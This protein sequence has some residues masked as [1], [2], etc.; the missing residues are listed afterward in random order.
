M[1]DDYLPSAFVPHGE[2]QELSMQ[3]PE[4]RQN[5]PEQIQ[6]A[7]LTLV[8]GSLRQRLGQLLNRNPRSAKYTLLLPDGR[9]LIL[10]CA[11]LSQLVCGCVCTEQNKEV[12]C[13]L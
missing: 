3:R 13:P 8:I 9:L 5:D 2:V 10:C 11:T 6:P 1:P 4:N 7:T 12:G